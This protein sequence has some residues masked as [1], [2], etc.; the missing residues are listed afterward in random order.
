MRELPKRC[1]M[2]VIKLKRINILKIS[3]SENGLMIIF[4]KP[5]YNESEIPSHT[6]YQCTSLYEPYLPSEGDEYGW[7]TL[8]K[9]VKIV[10]III[11]FD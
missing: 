7:N 11:L 10:N 8:F 9:L 3:S 1:G 6:H 5:K 2:E 4:F